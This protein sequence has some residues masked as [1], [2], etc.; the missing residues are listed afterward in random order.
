M[1]PSLSKYKIEI[2]LKSVIISFLCYLGFSIL[3]SSR[4]GSTI[5]YIK[6]DKKR[7]YFQSSEEEN[8]N[9]EMATSFLKI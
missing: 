2:F 3:A 7:G 8:E 9:T 4:L 6:V 1:G 5:V